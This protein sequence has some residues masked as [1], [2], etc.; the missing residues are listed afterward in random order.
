MKEVVERSDPLKRGLPKMS[1]NSVQISSWI[2]GGEGELGLICTQ[3]EQFIIR[4]HHF[5]LGVGLFYA[6][7]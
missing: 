4:L 7:V 5:I 1:G 3:R 6:C 2:V